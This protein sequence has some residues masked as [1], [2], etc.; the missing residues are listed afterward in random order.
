MLAAHHHL[1]MV[2]LKLE[3]DKYWMTG[4]MIEELFCLQGKGS[5]VYTVLISWL[6]FLYFLPPLPLCVKSAAFCIS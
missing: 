3:Q 5:G 4:D 6:S 2:D 1:F